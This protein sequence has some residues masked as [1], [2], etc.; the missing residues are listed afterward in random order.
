VT[1]AATSRPPGGDLL[2]ESFIRR[3][4]GLRLR[5][6]RVSA[7]SA[8]ARPGRQ[9]TPA[10]DFIDHRAY[11]PGDDIRHIDW[12]A[13][14]RLDEVH[15][16]VGQRPQ[17]A[18]VELLLDRSLSMLE[19]P[20]KWHLAVRLTAALGW[21]SLAAGDRVTVRSFPGAE[22]IWGPAAGL[23][24]AHQLL[25]AMAALSPR[26]GVSDPTGAFELVARDGRPGG[27]A[28][29]V[30]DFW[31]VADAEEALARVPAPRFD[32]LALH[33]LDPTELDPPLAGSYELVD[34]ESGATVAVVV[35]AS[36]RAAYRARM[37]AGVE[38]VRRL[39]TLRG[40]AHALAMASWPLERAVLPFLRGRGVL[41]ET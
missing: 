2:D 15:V 8:G 6:R 20:R 34:A 5:A 36:V 22:V 10:A 30:S 31:W 17:A 7:S 21:L 38:N 27:V 4:E 26:P 19:P 23:G 40:G 28:V 24:G 25:A 13:L 33:I 9:R 11:S 37:R 16:K 1:R 35:D 29:V 3:L 18:A 39:V 32:I 12:H 14:A 41:T